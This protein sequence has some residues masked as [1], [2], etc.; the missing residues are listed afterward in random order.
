[1]RLRIVSDSL[2]WVCKK[3][4]LTN[5]S[6]QFEKSG[7]FVDGSKLLNF[8]FKKWLNFWNAKKF[9]S[10]LICKGKN[11]RS[12]EVRIS[13]KKVVFQNLNE[14]YLTIPKI[15]KNVYLEKLL[16]NDGM[17][18]CL[19]IECRVNLWLRL[20]KVIGL[21]FIFKCISR[22]NKQFCSC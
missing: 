10:K 7:G 20:S 6:A 19:E 2:W 13:G 9:V 14:T 11:V 21:F 17:L 18:K 5:C 8:E 12:F 1:M 3:T 16:Q 22:V 15:K 4:V